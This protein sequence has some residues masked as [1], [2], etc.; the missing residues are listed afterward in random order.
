[1]VGDGKMLTLMT[2]PNP[3]PKP[4]ALYFAI[5]CGTRYWTRTPM[6]IASIFHILHLTRTHVQHTTAEI[7]YM[8]LHNISS[9]RHTFHFRWCI[10]FWRLL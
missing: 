6:H 4:I 3:D 9:T 10:H 1:M 5:R 8:Y 7:R 2:K